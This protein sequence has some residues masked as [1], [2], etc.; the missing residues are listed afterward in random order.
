MGTKID[1]SIKARLRGAIQHVHLPSKRARAMIAAVG[2]LFVVSTP[3]AFDYI[4][5]ASDT[6]KNTFQE[7]NLKPSSIP[8]RTFNTAL[9]KCWDA[10]LDGTIGSSTLVLQ[11]PK[12]TDK[13]QAI[14]Y[15]D[16]NEMQIGAG[17]ISVS[18]GSTTR[19]DIDEDTWV[20]LKDLGSGS[21][22][23]VTIS[24]SMLLDGMIKGIS[25]TETVPYYQQLLI[26][27]DQ[28]NPT[29][30]QVKSGPDAYL[31]FNMAAD[32]VYMETMNL[33]FD[34]IASFLPF[35]DTDNSKP[36]SF[37]MVMKNWWICKFPASLSYSTHTIKLWNVAEKTVDVAVVPVGDA[38]G[39]GLLN[40]QELANIAGGSTLDIEAKDNW[41]YMEALS[42]SYTFDASLSSEH[43]QIGS[44]LMHFVTP[45]ADVNIRISH[46]SAGQVLSNMIMR[47]VFTRGTYEYSKDIL[48]TNDYVMDI[49]PDG[50]SLA[51]L[52]QF[53]FKS[54]AS[55][56]NI[57][58]EN[59]AGTSIALVKVTTGQEDRDGDGLKDLSED[60]NVN[61]AY[62][63][64]S[65]FSDLTDMD[66]DGDGLIDS[67]DAIPNYSESFSSNQ[68]ART[69]LEYPT[70]A[71]EGSYVEYEL[72]IKISSTADIVDNWV[73]WGD[74]VFKIQPAIRFF[75]NDPAV[76]SSDLPPSHAYK[77][78]N[79]KFLPTAY[80][81]GNE[82]DDPLVSTISDNL[83]Y[84]IVVMTPNSGYAA[85][86]KVKTSFDE[87]TSWDDDDEN[88][89][90]E[91]YLRFD[92]VY[93]VLMKDK[94]GSIKLVHVYDYDAGFTIQDARAYFQAPITHV[95]VQTSGADAYMQM[96]V[97]GGYLAYQAGF[98]TNFVH[99]TGIAAPAS[100][101]YTS[102]ATQEE[103]YDALAQ[104]LADREYDPSLTMLVAVEVGYEA[105]A[106]GFGDYKNIAVKGTKTAIILIKTTISLIDFAINMYAWSQVLGV[107]ITKIKNKFLLFGSALVQRLHAAVGGEWVETITIF[108]QEKVGMF[109]ETVGFGLNC[110]D[111]TF[112][113]LTLIKCITG[114]A[115]AVNKN[116]P[117][118]FFKNVFS[119]TKLIVEKII[120]KVFTW[121]LDSKIWVMQNG[122]MM[123][124][125]DE[126][127]S[128]TNKLNNFGMGL[129]HLIDV[130]FDSI[131]LI[132][133]FNDYFE[134]VADGADQLIIDFLAW[135]IG[136]QFV[137]IILN[138]VA[139]IAYIAYGSA[140]T[141]FGAVVTV[142]CLIIEVVLSIVT[143]FIQAEEYRKYN[144]MLEEYFVSITHPEIEDD[145][146]PVLTDD[147]SLGLRTGDTVSLSTTLTLWENPQ[148]SLESLLK[149]ADGT[150][151]AGDKAGVL[152][153]CNR[154]VTPYFYDDEKP[155]IPFSSG[156]LLKIVNYIYKNQGFD[157]TA[158]SVTGHSETTFQD[159]QEIVTTS[160]TPRLAVLDR[161]WWA[162]Y[163]VVDDKT[164]SNN[165]GFDKISDSW[166]YQDSQLSYQDSLG[167]QDVVDFGPV[168]PSTLAAF[169]SLLVNS[170]DKEHLYAAT[171]GFDTMQGESINSI[172]QVISG[173]EYVLS[174]QEGHDRVLQITTQSTIN[175]ACWGSNLLLDASSFD[176]EIYSSI[177]EAGYTS[178][179]FS[180]FSWNSELLP[181]VTSSAIGHGSGFVEF[182]LYPVAST[183]ITLQ[184]VNM[185]ILT[186]PN[187][188][189]WTQGVWNHVKIEFTNDGGS[190]K[191]WM[192]VNDQIANSWSSL[193]P[194]NIAKI[195][196]TSTGCYVDALGCSWDTNY[197]LG[198]NKFPIDP[199]ESNFDSWQSLDLA[200]SPKTPVAG[201]QVPVYLDNAHFPSTLF[202]DCR[203]AGQ[204]IR[205]LSTSGSSLPYW[206]EKWD[207]ANK[208]AIIWVKVLEKGTTVITMKYDAP[209][210]LVVVLSRSNGESVF[211]FFDDFD[212]HTTSHSWNA[213]L[214][215]HCYEYNSQ[216]MMSSTSDW[217]GLCTKDVVAS[218]SHG[219]IV[220]MK[221]W[222]ATPLEFHAFQRLAGSNTIGP[223]W[224]DVYDTYQQTTI[225]AR[226]NDPSA[227][228]RVLHGT[229]STPVV[230]PAVTQ[231]ITRL[232]RAPGDKFSARILGSNYAYYGP[233][234]ASAPEN[235]DVNLARID[236]GDMKLYLCMN[237]VSTSCIYDW[238][239]VRKFTAIEPVVTMHSVTINL[240]PATPVDNLEVKITLDKNFIFADC[241]PSGEDIRFTDVDGNGLSYW[242]E[243]WDASAKTATIWVK[244]E[245]IGTTSLKLR[246]GNPI[247]SPCSNGEATFKF[248][249]DFSWYDGYNPAKTGDQAYTRL[250]TEKWVPSYYSYYIIED[251]TLFY[252]SN[253]DWATIM[254]KNAAL[255]PAEGGVAEMA[256][257]VSSS[258]NDLLMDQ[259]FLFSSVPG[260]SDDRGFGVYDSSQAWPVWGYKRVG[261]TN[262]YYT[263]GGVTTPVSIS[264]FSTTRITCTDAGKFSAGIY[265]ED[266]SLY[267][268]ATLATWKCDDLSGL[269]LMNLQLNIHP[270][271]QSMY[272][273]WVRIRKYHVVEPIASQPIMFAATTVSNQIVEITLDGTFD[274][275]KYQPNGYDVRFEDV[276]DNSVPHLIQWWNNNN[277]Q[278]KITLI[279]PD[280]GTTTV[281]MYPAK[282][283]S[284][285][286]NKIY[287]YTV[288]NSGGIMGSWSKLYNGNTIT[289]TTPPFDYTHNV[290]KL[291]DSTSSWMELYTTPPNPSGTPMTAGQVS[292]AFGMAV[293]SNDDIGY[294]SLMEGS[295]TGLMLGMYEG[296]FKY[297]YSGTFI[298]IATFQVNHIY[299]L[300]ITFDLQTDTFS[301]LIDGIPRAGPYPFSTPLA[302]VDKI[303]FSTGSA[304]TGYSLY[305]GQVGYYCHSTGSFKEERFE[306]Y[307]GTIRNANGW[308]AWT[309]SAGFNFQ[310]AQDLS[311]K[312]GHGSWT[313]ASTVYPELTWTTAAP[314]GCG[315]VAFSVKVVAGFELNIGDATD[316][317]RVTVRF[318]PDGK[319]WNNNV[320][321]T[322]ISWSSTAY[323][324]ILIVVDSASTYHLVVN[325]VA[326]AQ[327][328][329]RSTFSGGIKRLSLSPISGVA[330][331]CYIDNIVTSWSA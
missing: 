105:A 57:A 201:C 248:F 115:S 185:D 329:A 230:T 322:S 280:V 283:A 264:E 186:I 180:D 26:S 217:A 243:R 166:Y 205:F 29:T 167:Y 203:P 18:G 79:S 215:S 304:P 119:L 109:A 7:N 199:Q 12:P 208:Q 235:W 140:A 22:F 317:K 274:Y 297:Y 157:E 16:I 113:A 218:A 1:K 284:Q 21:S 305:V 168:L 193:L 84:D 76:G 238:V 289:E 169:K 231:V 330:G 198:S 211:E 318:A 291:T 129:D 43:E 286:S 307:T 11:V 75:G 130:I 110:L 182:W 17:L 256:W 137:K 101:S 106:P 309:Q 151:K 189:G 147:W 64:S 3:L 191:C 28:Q 272:Y 294:I 142:A 296:K 66:T 117:W 10:S 136:L 49:T 133:M 187:N 232:T 123:M 67:G 196:F 42:T 160:L 89:I 172:P 188:S 118:N 132:F 200:I 324:A 221:W 52:Y 271:S 82:D 93:A 241:Q 46:P 282:P 15:L 120:P 63:T 227:G 165:H 144:L 69:C 319:I 104:F 122:Y 312:R 107:S 60:F 244:V 40:W 242:I 59:T 176:K 170:M 224:F 266:G 99:N 83:D 153:L 92:L 259:R 228:N 287:P 247:A 252:S 303:K 285:P 55:Y 301:L 276:N 95:R 239:R 173:D 24:G 88:T 127:A 326:T 108:D 323:Q 328:T 163:Y 302:T 152:W 295:T 156:Y 253:Y 148:N 260:E 111:Y 149:N 68:V 275:T 13:T 19:S 162:G 145:W 316:G 288:W 229:A 298:E 86:Y 233:S 91:M 251:S 121:W 50:E 240:A 265:R 281:N 320:G 135:S 183:V 255:D 214:Y 114:I 36:I 290:V 267:G 179:W 237:P 204:D 38:D 124:T 85:Q 194:W 37:Q 134:A 112:I 219:G 25:I 177:T 9:W 327:Y 56:T 278:S 45:T 143:L 2:L 234:P 27:S 44:I 30:F 315:T 195:Q 154:E 51:G 131:E 254:T 35:Q 161:L 146:N 94:S 277:K 216:L 159:T 308:N 80:I 273:D 31:V 90:P 8:Y 220:E 310:A 257:R 41:F 261:S 103:F 246:Y 102:G 33:Q 325:G 34:S 300:N 150:L 47:K 236:P 175:L 292:C 116:D 270:L 70:V 209:A 81:S 158:I 141:G 73:A 293:T 213:D 331:D 20:L 4:T 87:S 58:F 223:V 98:I 249:D 192:W 39:D 202:S 212:D 74:A 61:D 263:A 32:Q 258:T 126:I 313:S 222:P 155:A 210:S 78:G 190:F 71:P 23:S 128:A 225:N 207:A 171:V 125:S 262:T 6:L 299:T 139:L 100:S 178:A 14:L 269:G 314:I 311:S 250:N 226:W 53:S 54:I 268:P 306:S 321:S 245:K 138:V 72:S 65:E 181:T 48:W 197:M 279:V 174:E 164:T 97:Y 184:D 62:D 77:A 206:I 96:F 5:L